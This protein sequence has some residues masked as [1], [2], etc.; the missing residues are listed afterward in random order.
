MKEELETFIENLKEDR[1]TF[2]YDEAATK[3][4]IVLRLLSVLGWNTYNIEEVTPEYAVKGRKV[5]YCLRVGN[6]NKVFLEVK[7]IGEELENHQEQLLSYSFKEGVTLAILTNGMRWWFYLPLRAGD[8]EERRFYT[9]D[10]RQQGSEEIVSKFINFLSKE[11]IASGEAIQNAEEVCKSYRKQLILKDALPKAWNKIIADP[12][13]MLIDLVSETT[14][15][16]CGHRPNREMVERL[17]SENKDGLLIS[18]VPTTRVARRDSKGTSM[19]LSRRKKSRAE[20]CKEALENLGGEA[21]LKE[22]YKEVGHLKDAAGEERIPNFEAAIRGCLETNSRGMG[23]DWFQPVEI[24][25]GM[26]RSKK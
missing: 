13:E 2:S 17:I 15:E 11:N 8:W 22:I 23:R 26:W 24:G 19:G 3:Q 20:Y 10:I 21:H 6:A 5:D 18:A 12:D 7:K 14:E 9:M 16:L 4:A 25:S 1:K